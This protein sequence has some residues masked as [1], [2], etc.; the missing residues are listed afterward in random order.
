MMT[1]KPWNEIRNKAGIE[2]AGWA[3]EA[4]WPSDLVFSIEK[5]NITLED[6]TKTIDFE[7]WW[8]DTHF[9]YE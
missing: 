8:I 9:P 2:A 7:L 1:A 4:G 3:R 5:G 6:A